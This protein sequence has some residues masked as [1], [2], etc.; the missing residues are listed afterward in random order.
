MLAVPVAAAAQPAGKV[1]R[2]R[3]DLQERGWN[4]GVNIRTEYRRVEGNAAI[5]LTIPQSVLLRADQVLDQ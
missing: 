3:Q 2:F 1:Y 5:R 4:E